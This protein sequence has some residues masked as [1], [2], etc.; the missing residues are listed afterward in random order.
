[1][2]EVLRRKVLGWINIGPLGTLEG[3]QR[4]ME[5]TADALGADAVGMILDLLV[6]AEID[7]G[8]EDFLDSALE[9][10]Q[11]YAARFPQVTASAGLSRL[12]ILGPASIVTVLGATGERDIVP[13]LLDV[14]DARRSPVDVVIALVDCLAEL[15]GEAS[16]EGLEALQGG[17]GVHPEVAE[18]IG[19]ALRVIESRR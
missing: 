2:N 11:V 17:E 13:R 4:D 6:A 19:V 7:G 5:L 15:G 8:D 18:E 12:S 9:F 3:R 16:R 10:A 1:M 14:I